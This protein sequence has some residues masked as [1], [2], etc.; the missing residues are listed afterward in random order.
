VTFTGFRDDATPLMAAMD[1]F[2]SA[3]LRETGPLTVLEA[4]ALGRAVI[5]SRVGLVPEAISDGTNGLIVPPGD[6]LAL[7]TAMETLV[8]DPALR[9]TFGER[10][11]AVVVERFS[12]TALV[13]AVETHYDSLLRVQGHASRP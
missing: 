12:A 9:Q 13:R 1:I 6:L 8:A 11:R 5:S 7:V 3:S 4:M 2:V 10:G